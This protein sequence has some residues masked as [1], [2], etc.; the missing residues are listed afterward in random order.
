MELASRAAELSADL[1]PVRYRP[2]PASASS[3]NPLPSSTSAAVVR[4]V[5]VESCRKIRLERDANP[6]LCRMCPL[7]PISPNQTNE[8]DAGSRAPQRKRILWTP[9]RLWS[10]LRAEDKRRVATELGCGLSNVVAPAGL[11]S[12][13]GC[14][15]PGREGATTVPERQ[16]DW[17]SGGIVLQRSE[18]GARSAVRILRILAE[19]P[20]LLTA[21]RVPLTEPRSRACSMAY[22][23]YSTAFPGSARLAEGPELTSPCL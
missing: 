13:S 15:R 4:P 5:R 12:A 3:G 1:A 20:A 8:Q 10:A 23:T 22:S 21:V 19:D 16:L 2:A 9:N 14:R 6:R 18:A 17:W 11:R 7:D